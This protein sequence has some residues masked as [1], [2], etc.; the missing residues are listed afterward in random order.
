MEKGLT[1]R[2]N[3][4]L[5]GAN[6]IISAAQSVHDLV[7]GA[8]WELRVIIFIISGKQSEIMVKSVWAS[9]PD[10]SKFQARFH[11]F[12]TVW[13]LASHFLSEAQFPYVYNKVSTVSLPITEPV[14]EVQR[15][16]VCR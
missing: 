5:E 1:T 12:L 9:E 3:G 10:S 6:K 4:I 2:L 15:C 7:K 14:G 16:A 13:P 11:H 8:Q